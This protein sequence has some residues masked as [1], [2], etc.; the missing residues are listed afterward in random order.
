MQSQ[1]T[2]APSP[3]HSALHWL[4]RQ[5]SN[6]SNPWAYL[7]P[8][9]GSINPM[10]VKGTVAAR[11]VAIEDAARDTRT[12]VLKPAGHWSGFKP[13]Q[14]LSLTVEINGARHT[15][16]FSLS[17]LPSRWKQDREITLT[18]KRL[19]G[20]L[21]TNWLHDYLKPGAVVTLGD[22]FGD[23]LL[24]ANPQ[25]LLFIAGGSGI[26]PI[27]SQLSTL[28]AADYPKP[29]TLLYYVRTEA[30]IIAAKEL[31]QM[32]GQW[33]NF[34]LKIHTT[35]D[36]GVMTAA[37]LPAIS[38]LADYHCYLCGPRGLMDLAGDLLGQAG[39]S[40]SQISSTFFSAPQVTLDTDELG[41]EVAFSRSGK[42]V[43][44]D[45]ETSLLELAES[46]GLK[47]KHGCR[48]GVCH[49]CACTKKTGIV[50]NRLTG[51]ASLPGEETIQLCVS[52]PQGPVDIVI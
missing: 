29:V 37:H 24:P 38:K 52:V 30:D 11:V 2:P 32:E 42:T 28:A 34:Q 22:A 7:D 20:G 46:A 26:T 48:M 40:E 43:H 41:G 27:L 50:M 4:G 36:G 35:D 16:T 12:F 10:L 17:C 33:D 49:Q 31:Y 15:R 25:P 45:G 9:L 1:Q 18:I 6:Q 13:G 21:V 51:K 8:I 14:H 3:W 39:V 5:L 23:F 19:P 47:P 44:S